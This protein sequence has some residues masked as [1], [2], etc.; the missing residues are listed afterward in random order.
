MR[1]ARIGTPATAAS[2]ITLAPPSLREDS[3]IAWLR[4]SSRRTAARGTSPR[5][6]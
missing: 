4:S 5:Q 2:E 3:T 1:D 6:R